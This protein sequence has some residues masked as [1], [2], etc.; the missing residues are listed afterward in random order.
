MENM[1]K[2][3]EHLKI[4]DKVCLVKFL[5][6]LHKKQLFITPNK[7]VDEDYDLIPKFLQE[8]YG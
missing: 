7:D 1:E 6:Y 2:E 4:L 5:Y 3:V 8:E